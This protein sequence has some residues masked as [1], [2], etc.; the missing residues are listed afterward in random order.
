MAYG[1]VD[2]REAEIKR[3][4]A[5][6]RAAYRQVI[7]EILTATT[8]GKIQRLS[9]MRNIKAIL[10]EL[11]S[12]V[13]K[14]VKQE[15]PQ[16]YRDGADGAIRELRR[17]DIDPT[18][19]VYFSQIHKEAIAALVEEITLGFTESIRGVARNASMLLN[20]AFQMEINQLIAQG[21]ITGEDRRIIAGYIKERLR[22]QGLNVLIDKSGRKWTFDR[23][24]EMLIRTKAVEARNMGLGNRIAENGFDLVEVSNHNSDHEAC[25][26]WE[27]KILS[28]TGRTPGYPT[29]NSALAAGLF[30]PNCQHSINV[31]NKELAGRTKAYDNP[32]NQP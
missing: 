16:Y 3:L 8:F 7:K 32:Y 29:Y 19:Q 11:G 22:Q 12:D 27:G 31:I 17:Q 18:K 14:W 10:E 5:T 21:F 24:T 26:V 2:L 25:A 30:H 4:I 13:D 6:Y 15:I 1:P 20:D 28:F 9:V 23:Y